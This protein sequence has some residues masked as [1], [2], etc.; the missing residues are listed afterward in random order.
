MDSRYQARLLVTEAPARFI[1]KLDNT[2]VAEELTRVVLTVEIS[3]QGGQVQWLADG[4]AILFGG[5]NKHLQA[6]VSG[7][8]R[9]LIIDE[10]RQGQDEVSIRKPPNKNQI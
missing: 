10:C 3:S 1:K 7:K 9:S 5:R 8:Y 4:K 6:V 2:T